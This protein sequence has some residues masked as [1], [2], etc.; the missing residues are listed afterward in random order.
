MKILYAVQKTGNGHVARAQE[1]IPILKQYGT[2]EILASGNQSQIQLPFAINYNFKGISLIYNEKGEVSYWKTLLNNNYWT[3]L[4]DIIQLKT[5]KYDLIINDFE[6]ISAWAS[7]FKGGT[8]ISLSHQASLFFK[9]TPKPKK[10]DLIA[11][12]ILKYYAPCKRKYG[13][14]FENYHDKIFTPVIREKIRNLKP[15]LMHGNYVVYLPS[16]SDAKIIKTLSKIKGEWHIYSKYA[17][18]NYFINNCSIYP[19]NEEDFLFK[20]SHCEGV[21]CN[22]GF[23]LPAEALYLKKKLL[24]IPIKKQIEQEYNAIALKKM[25]VLTLKRLDQNLISIWSKSNVSLN[26]EYSTNLELIIKE[27]I[28]ENVSLTTETTDYHFA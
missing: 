5:K 18:S 22:A 14:H 23:E 12:I 27:I 20:L 8:I 11:Q 21:L 15:K 28:E 1:I 2:V 19:I 24:V 10:S 7:F 13:F 3:F 25:G 16:F 26:L 4:K 9:E 6:P 17:T